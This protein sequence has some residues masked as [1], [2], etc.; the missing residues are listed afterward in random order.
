MFGGNSIWHGLVW[1]LVNYLLII[2][3]KR[4]ASYY[5]ENF[6]IECLTGF[7]NFLAIHVFAD[8]LALGMDG[9]GRQKRYC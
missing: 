8:E 6:K 4:F 1:F 5:G 9:E 7:D 3:L 2:S